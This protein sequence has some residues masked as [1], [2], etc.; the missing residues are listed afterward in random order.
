M[1]N[2]NVFGPKG[3][4]SK[5]S[6]FLKRAGS[7]RAWASPSAS[8][9]TDSVGFS[10]ARSNRTGGYNRLPDTDI[11]YQTLQRSHR[12]Y[13]VC[14]LPLLRPNH[15]LVLTIT[16]LTRIVDLTYATF[17]VPLEIASFVDPAEWSVWTALDL[18]AGAVYTAEVYLRINTGVEVHNEG[19]VITI[20]DGG[21][22]ARRHV[23]HELPM[24]LA[25]VAA[26]IPAWF[27]AL[28]LLGI[29]QAHSLLRQLLYLKL[30]RIFAVIRVI[31]DLLMVSLSGQLRRRIMGWLPADV[32]YIF[33]IVYGLLALLNL[34]G[35][36]WL[37][38]ALREDMGT[39]WLADVGGQ[40]LTG[41]P[42]V[43]QYVAAL[44]FAM[45]TMT[46]V[47]YGDI[48]PKTVAERVC[49]MIIMGVGIMFFGFLISALGE[50]LR[51]ASTS[52]RRT[53]LLHEKNKEVAA[54][55]ASRHL[56]RNLQEEVVHYYA[57]TWIT[58]AEVREAELLDEL[59]RH[60]RGK[61]VLYFLAE[62][63]DGADLF[64]HLDAVT[65]ELLAGCLQ[66]RPLLP[67]HDLCRPGDPANCLWILQK[68]TIL[69]IQNLQIVDVLHSPAI[70]GESVILD[71]EV[72]AASKIRAVSFRAQGPCMV[73]ELGMKDLQAL[74]FLHPRIKDDLQDGFRNHLDYRLQQP[75]PGVAP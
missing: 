57:D 70:L 64:S 65:K 62:V 27:Q 11:T 13:S 73:W 69:A 29:V 28:H 20:M 9:L 35:C 44:S 22:A 52:A 61:I 34:L 60:L 45:T 63:F 49:A 53:E 51:E 71:D 26:A 72:S 6:D 10:L 36:T 41:A 68:G 33:C 48:T 75:S 31:R 2:H 58:Q 43:Q 37:W 21:V 5:V 30:L 3:D 15:W 56:P 55:L 12:A 24:F 8:S 67:G 66:A 1:R 42:L 59:P 16:L 40:D 50:L 54:W 38:L 23:L 14:G 39:S 4:N 46:T 25:D 19:R 17:G 32:L 74:M 18:L 7:R 47:G